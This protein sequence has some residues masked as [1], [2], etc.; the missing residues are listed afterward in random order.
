MLSRLT[1]PPEY[2]SD[3]LCEAFDGE[4]CDD[5]GTVLVWEAV[6]DRAVESR[7]PNECEGGVHYRST[8]PDPDEAY[9]A[10]YDL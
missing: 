6:D 9:E 7:C 3:E 10:H 8:E 5:C 1:N 4:V 2:P